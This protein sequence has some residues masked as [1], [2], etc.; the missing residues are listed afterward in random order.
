MGPN[1]PQTLTGIETVPGLVLRPLAGPLA[2]PNQPQTLTGIETD[3]T[4]LGAL[5]NP[6]PNQPQTLTGIETY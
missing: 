2:R 4:T 5:Q 3:G 6:R 1:Q